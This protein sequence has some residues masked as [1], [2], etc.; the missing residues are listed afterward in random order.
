M[1]SRALVPVHGT[2][3][4]SSLPLPVRQ[5]RYKSAVA[6]SHRRI[7]L[8][9][10]KKQKKSLRH[11]F[12]LIS[13]LRPQNR[14]AYSNLKHYPL[15]PAIHAS[16]FRRQLDFAFRHS[17]RPRRQSNNLQLSPL[18]TDMLHLLHQ[19]HRACRSLLPHHVL[20]QPRIPG[21]EAKQMEE[22]SHDGYERGKG[23]T[24]AFKPRDV[25]GAL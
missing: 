12:T 1:T 14:H 4:D 24:A 13:K 11:L 17:L 9:R 16:T 6:G 5:Q 3:L 7:S 22:G 19:P 2:G 25:M 23:K 21:S 15:P 20:L 8:Q 18:C 10:S